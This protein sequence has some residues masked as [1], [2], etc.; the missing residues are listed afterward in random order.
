MPSRV[1]VECRKLEAVER[2]PGVPCGRRFE[3]VARYG[4][5]LAL[6]EQRE[7]RHVDADAA[8]V[9]THPEPIRDDALVRLVV[10]EPPQLRQAP[11]QRPARVVR[12]LPEQLAQML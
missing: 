3:L 4:V 6:H 8:R 10:D 11:T 5:E 9:E 2:I 7:L 12:D 1:I